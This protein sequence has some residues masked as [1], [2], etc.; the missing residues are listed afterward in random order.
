MKFLGSNLPK[1][2][3][4]RFRSASLSA[5]CFCNASIF[6]RSES[7]LANNVSYLIKYKIKLMQ[8]ALANGAAGILFGAGER[9]EQ[10]SSQDG[11]HGDHHGQFHQGESC[12]TSSLV[13][14]AM[15]D[16]L[17]FHVSTGLVIKICAFCH[18]TATKIFRRRIPFL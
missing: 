6:C 13:N 16:S 8:V 15:N 10:K 5:N 12:G 17:L 14:P 1:R 11:G 3:R 18:T 2:R 7:L 4:K 9:G